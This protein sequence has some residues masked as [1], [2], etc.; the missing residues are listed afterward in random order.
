MWQALAAG[1]RAV[2]R[3]GRAVQ[4]AP[5]RPTLKTLEIKL[6]KLNSEEPL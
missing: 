5:I 4:D 6:L 3:R 2:G 1:A